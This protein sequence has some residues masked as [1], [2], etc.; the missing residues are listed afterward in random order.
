MQCPQGRKRGRQT[1]DRRAVHSRCGR[2]WCWRTGRSGQW[3]LLVNQWLSDSNKKLYVLLSAEQAQPIG[4]LVKT[5]GLNSGEVLA[6]LSLLEMKGVAR[7]F[8][9]KQFTRV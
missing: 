3:N 5:S 6:T 9:G 1:G 2:F 4:R 7:Q 8:P